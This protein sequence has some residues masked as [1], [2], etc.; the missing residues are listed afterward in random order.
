MTPRSKP[1]IEFVA[2]LAACALFL[3]TIE[4]LIPKPL[5]FMRLGLANLP[6]IIALGLLSWKEYLLL[7][8]LKV[9]GQ[10]LIS[11]TIFSYIFL[12]SLAG[13]TA[14]ILIM[15]LLYNVLKKR[16]SLIGISIAG[17]MAS[18]IAQLLLSR[19]LLFGE[20]AK[21]VAPPFLIVGLVTSIILGGFAQQFIA[22]SRWYKGVQ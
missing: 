3:S 14:S 1:R 4:Y 18:N 7:A 22:K 2:L 13:T 16:V 15:L 8:L 10:A 6:L 19:Y 11:G 20:A 5:P 17:A 12:F 21:L 9:L